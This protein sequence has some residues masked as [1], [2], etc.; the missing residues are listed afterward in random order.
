MHKNLEILAPV[1]SFDSLKAAVSNGANAVY[2]GG[3]E[4]SARASANNFD[5]KELIDAVKYAHIRGVNVFITVNTLIKENEVCDFIEY[6]GFLNNI[7][8]DAVILQ[9]IGMVDLIRNKYPDLELHASTQMAAHSLEDVLFLEKVGFKRVVLARELNV[10]EIKYITENS[11]ADIE[12]FVHGAL[13]V[14]YSGQC[15]MS[16][17]LGT[18]SGNRG[19]CAQPCR[20]QYRLYDIDNDSY[21]NTDGSYLLSPRDLNT[22]EEINRIIDTNVLSLKIEGRMKKPEYV[23]TVVSTY[24]K[25]IDRIN[26]GQK[27]YVHNI[28]IDNLYSIFNRKFT[29]GYILN[30]VGSDIMNS[31]KPN[32]QGLFIGN[33]I[34]YDAKNKKLKIKLEKELKKGDCLN[35]G[36]GNIGRIIKSKKIYEIGYPGEIIEIDYIGDVKKSTPLYKTSDQQLLNTAKATYENDVEI[37]KIP[38]NADV[39]ICVDSP[40]ILNLEDDDENFVSLTGS[41][42]VEKAI[43]VPI[44]EEKVINQISKLGN[45]PY[46]I[47][48]IRVHL[49]DNSTIPVSE[50]NNIRR[51]AIEKLSA[52]RSNKKSKPQPR[53]EKK[54]YFKNRIVFE[55]IPH[56]NIS[57]HNIEQLKSIVD[58]NI[59]TVYYKDINTLNIALDLCSKHGVNLIL[60]LPRI[61]RSFEKRHYNFLNSLS[62]EVVDRIYGFRANNYGEINVLNRLFPEKPIFIS[63]WLNTINSSS[64]KFYEDINASIISL[65]QEMSYEQMKKLPSSVNNDN[66][67]E[68]LIYGKRE[69]MI[70]EYCPMGVLTKDC[71]KN[72]RDSLCNK[73]MYSL[74]SSNGEGYRLRQDE[75]C[76]T[77]IYSDSIL[78]LIDDIDLIKEVGINQF[79]IN[80]TFE[81]GNDSRFIVS[82]F[83][84]KAKEDS[85]KPANLNKLKLNFET[86]HFYKEID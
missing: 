10:K 35:I 51:E 83:V 52:V 43:R 70:S 32:N 74:V 26:S 75:N 79:E 39:Y 12:V 44:S 15:L 56:L 55:S 86:G 37:K 64:I 59:D 34:S 2:L 22:V 46:I 66:R 58:L 14:A 53:T 60:D 16:S 28:D 4:F 69:M 27:K 82:E 19:R 85:S 54:A 36:G 7:G 65:S 6:I 17:I 61:I 67:L 49:E 73:S 31:N 3:K 25:A 41:K 18:R 1:G 11:T 47:N 40:V 81:S 62:T 50:L 29:K 13:C 9:D 8:V 63:P 24:K 30:E 20:Q 33:V 84:K 71:K 68:Y 72:K 45:T 76:R 57:V 48:D 42:L 78:N 77:T 21:I 38:I 80:L 23:A 5:R